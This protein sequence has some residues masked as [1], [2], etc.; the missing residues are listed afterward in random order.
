MKLKTKDLQHAVAAAKAAVPNSTTIEI[1]RCVLLTWGKGELAATGSDTNTTIS[2]HVPCEAEGRGAIA[3]LGSSLADVVRGLPGEDVELSQAGS[4]RLEIRS[5]RARY[6]LPYLGA[7]DFPETPTVPLIMHEVDGGAIV[8]LVGRVFASVSADQTRHHIAG[9]LV[10][11]SEWVSTD[12][13]R[14]MVAKGSAA[15]WPFKQPAL[16]PRDALSLIRKTIGGGNVRMGMEKGVLTV[17][18]VGATLAVR[19]NDAS[20]FPAWNQVIPDRGKEPL[21]I[22]RHELI[23]ALKHVS[24]MA[25]DLGGLKFTLSAGSLV[26]N[27][28]HPNHG[29]AEERIDV[30]GC[31][32][33]MVTGFSGRYW[34][35]A[36]ETMTSERVDVTLGAELDPAKVADGDAALAV[37]M[38]MRI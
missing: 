23:A 13:H 7:K 1:M 5:G 3:V 35:Q 9:A 10:A 16:I 18:T 20:A 21:S 15:A 26:L 6:V 34:L 30:P 32:R 37:I 28:E 8:E 2:A 22:D 29:D 14:M 19:V 31:A 12:G 38:P 25:P 17:A 11:Q 36:L 24:I 33:S 27:S 4:G